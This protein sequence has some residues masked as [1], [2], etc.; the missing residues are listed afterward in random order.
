MTEAGVSFKLAGIPISETGE[1]TAAQLKR[2]EVEFMSPHAD[3]A[4]KL[5]PALLK[6]GFTPHSPT[7]A[8]LNYNMQMYQNHVQFKP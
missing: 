6:L 2:I 4:E 8:C 1:L 3:L 5:W 7:M